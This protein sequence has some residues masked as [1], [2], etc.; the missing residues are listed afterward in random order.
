MR[1]VLRSD[2]GSSLPQLRAIDELQQAAISVTVAVAVSA[3]VI[4]MVTATTP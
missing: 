3:I 2:I 1:D 4:A